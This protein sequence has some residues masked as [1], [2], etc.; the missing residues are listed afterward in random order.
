MKAFF[1]F[2]IL[3]FII[4]T[5]AGCVDADKRQNAQVLTRT[6]LLVAQDEASA[7]EIELVAKGKM[8]MP[9]LQFKH[10]E[11]FLN[12]LEAYRNGEDEKAA[13]MAKSIKLPESP[14]AEI[15]QALRMSQTEGALQTSV[16]G[17][18]NNLGVFTWAVEF[19]DYTEV[20]TYR[21]PNHEKITVS[22]KARTPLDMEITSSTDLTGTSLPLCL[23]KQITNTELIWFCGTPYETW[24]EVHVNRKLGNMVQLLCEPD[25]NGRPGLG[26]LDPTTEQ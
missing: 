10:S 1:S 19:P 11:G 26:C 24:K 15:V 25:E 2:L 13:S 14:E 18:Q 21:K 8:A 16:C 12:W 9:C 6:P 23:P 4:F 3:G 5:S 17:I 7:A 22:M 20:Y